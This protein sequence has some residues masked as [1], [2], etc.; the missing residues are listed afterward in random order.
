MSPIPEIALIVK[1]DFKGNIV[2]VSGAK[3]LKVV[4]EPIPPDKDVKV[5]N[6]SGHAVVAWQTNPQN[7]VTYNIPGGSYTV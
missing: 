7:C 5:K 3:D 1:I 2:E 6:V 4:H